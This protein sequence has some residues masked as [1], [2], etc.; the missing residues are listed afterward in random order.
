MEVYQPKQY[1][2]LAAGFADVHVVEG[3]GVEVADTRV[4]ALR[5]HKGHVHPHVRGRQGLPEADNLQ[6]F[7]V[8]LLSSSVS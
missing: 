3:D 1:A 4:R 7:I 2:L 8:L 5:R 6:R